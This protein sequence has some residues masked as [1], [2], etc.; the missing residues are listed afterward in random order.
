MAAFDVCMS[1]GSNP[2]PTAAP[3]IGHALRFMPATSRHDR[4][5]LP[6]PDRRG[7]AHHPRPLSQ[8]RGRD[9]P[10]GN[11]FTIGHPRAGG[12][13]S[14]PPTARAP[15]EPRVSR[16]RASGRGSGRAADQ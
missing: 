11:D 15:G 9:V 12:G 8:V 2:D 16:E 10:G 1:H 14:G 3:R 4:H 7:A 5:D 6:I 13:E